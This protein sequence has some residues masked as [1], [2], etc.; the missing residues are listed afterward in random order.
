M[1]HP[2]AEIIFADAEVCIVMCPFCNCLHKHGEIWGANDARGSHCRRG[3][4]ILGDTVKDNELFNAIKRRRYELQM[5]KKQYQKKKSL[6]K[7]DENT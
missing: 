1:S 5:K 2:K 7:V 4:Y 3:D 6:A